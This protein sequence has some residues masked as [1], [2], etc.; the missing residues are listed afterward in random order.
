MVLFF[1]KFWIFIL[2]K[3]FKLCSKVSERNLV[4]KSFEILRL[5]NTADC[6]KALY[7]IAMNLFLW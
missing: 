4:L 6:F 1:L 7:Y 2:I 5:K 3:A